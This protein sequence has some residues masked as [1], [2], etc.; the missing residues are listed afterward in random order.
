MVKIQKAGRLLVLMIAA[1]LL[2]SVPASVYAEEEEKKN[3][4]GTLMN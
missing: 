1:V 2:F 3:I 4:L